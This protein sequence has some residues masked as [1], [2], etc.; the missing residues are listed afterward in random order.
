MYGLRPGHSD[1]A[2]KGMLPQVGEHYL[3]DT[4]EEEDQEND[5][6]YWRFMS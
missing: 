5:R 3:N 4:T 1:G 2:G 6:S